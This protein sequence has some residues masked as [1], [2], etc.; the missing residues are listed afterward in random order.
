MKNH[1][2]RMGD[3]KKTNFKLFSLKRFLQTIRS[4]L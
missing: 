4:N 3:C 1:A 2:A